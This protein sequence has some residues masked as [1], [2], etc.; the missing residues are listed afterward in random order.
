MRDE[1]DELGAEWLRGKICGAG[2]RFIRN[3]FV[4]IENRGK[5][6]GGI[7]VLRPLVVVVAPATADPELSLIHISEPT[8]PY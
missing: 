4:V 8:R 1:L 3:E 7:T 2:N 6:I 5:K